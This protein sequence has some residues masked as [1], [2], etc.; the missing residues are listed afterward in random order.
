MSLAFVFPGQGSQA[1]GM[2]QALAEA[3]P[4]ARHTL[5]EVDDALEQHLSRLMFEGPE[6]ELRLT[7]N[8][9]PALMAASLAALRVFE[10]E[11]GRPL[12][13]RAAFVAGHSL[14]EY[15]ALAAAGALELAD[16]AR[17]LRRRGEAMQEAVPVG[18]GAMAALLG[19]ELDAAEEI[20]Q[21]AAE[22]QVCAAANDNAPGQVVLSGHREAID[23]AIELAKGRGAK[24]AI[25]LP[26][27]APFHCSLMAPA[28]D[29]MADALATVS[30]KMP[31]VPLVANVTAARLSDPDE[32]RR[33]LVEQVTG[34]VRWRESVAYMA[35]QGVE[36]TVELGAGKVLTGL[37]KRI[38]HGLGAVAAGTPEELEKLLQQL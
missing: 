18:E 27:S 23:R 12:A 5:Q 34:K 32:I 38:D 3:F 17:L 4:V 16:T 7:A 24:R 2:G 15:S 26:V 19:L 35:S 22:D 31:A 6:D 33:K 8:A 20:A 28:A 9:Q 11:G 14:G 10:Q 21:E 25:Q 36:T 29:V 37:S 30:I 13:E 1:V